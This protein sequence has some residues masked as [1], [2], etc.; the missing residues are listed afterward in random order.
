MHR[1]GQ[2]ATAAFRAR[3]QGC[4]TASE[5]RDDAERGRGRAER[6]RE[7]STRAARTRPA[8][9]L[10]LDVKRK[11]HREVAQREKCGRSYYP[12]LFIA[13]RLKEIAKLVRGRNW[14]GLRL[15][16]NA[17]TLWE[18]E[19]SGIRMGGGVSRW[20]WARKRETRAAR[21]ENR[22]GRQQFRRG[23]RAAPAQRAARAR[24]VVER[25]R[26]RNVARSR[27]SPVSRCVASEE[28]G[29]LGRRGRIRWAVDAERGGRCWLQ[30][31]PSPESDAAAHRSG[32]VL[33][34]G[35]DG[36]GRGAAGRGSRLGRSRGGGG[37]RPSRT[38]R[39]ELC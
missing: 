11:N 33:G 38:R 22:E 35:F 12:S 26:K 15:L 25:G 20:L 39:A 24:E 37:A 9:S 6:S 30:F 27:G 28:G 36:A 13:R 16:L 29:H 3:A 34:K 31:D 10:A 17:G 18:R 32:G 21:I 23:A 1:C 14:P 19:G 2:G 8:L 7:R 4:G 5:E